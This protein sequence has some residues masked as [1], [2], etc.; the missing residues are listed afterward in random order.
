MCKGGKGGRSARGCAKGGPLC[1]L[2]VVGGEDGPSSPFPVMV[3]VRGACKG[4]KGGERGEE[5]K[6]GVQKEQLC[7]VC[8]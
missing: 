1:G 3:S 7:G 6:G 5:C 8:V 4:G 2:C